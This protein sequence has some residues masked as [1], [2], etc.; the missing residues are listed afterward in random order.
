MSQRNV[1]TQVAAASVRGRSVPAQVAAV[2]VS[3]LGYR[4]R[5]HE[6]SVELQ[7][8]ALALIGP[9]GAG[10]STLLHLLV[11]RLKPHAGRVSL[12]GHAPRSKEAAPLRAYVPQQIQFPAHLQV[13]EILLAAAQAKGASV[14][15]AEFALDRMGMLGFMLRRAGALSGGMT[16]RLALAAALMDEPPLW[17]LDEPASALDG[18]GLERLAAWA[19]D[20]VAAGGSLVV[21]AHRPEEVEAFASEALLLQGGRVAGRQDVHD[22]FEYRVLDGSSAARP[23]PAG[24]QVQRRASDVL[25]EVLGSRDE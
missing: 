1:P 24:W 9:N 14:E 21:S 20:H 8:G 18:G 17:L 7:G 11:G 4:Q 16:Q 25:Q 5:L 12:F 13:R 23:L 19:R 10:K 22:L 3:G 2:S 6:V 15:A